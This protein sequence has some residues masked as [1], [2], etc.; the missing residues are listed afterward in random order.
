MPCHTKN[1]P[2]VGG[3]GKGVGGGGKGVGGG[4]GLHCTACGILVP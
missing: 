4:Q 3:G 2:L 1:F